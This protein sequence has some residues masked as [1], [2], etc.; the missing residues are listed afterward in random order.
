MSVCVCVHTLMLSIEAQPECVYVLRTLLFRC[1]I[2]AWP[3][4]FGFDICNQG[5]TF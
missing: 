5:K 4:L 2:H 1:E 3:N